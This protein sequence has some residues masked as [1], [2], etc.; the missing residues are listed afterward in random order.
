[1]TNGSPPASNRLPKW[2]EWAIY[3][4]FGVLLVSGGAWL[5]LHRLVTVAGA[6]GPEPSPFEP[7][8]LQIHGVVAYVFLVVAGA[9]IPNHIRLGWLAR[10]NHYT[11]TTTTAAMLVLALSG[12]ALYYVGSESLRPWTSLAHWAVGLGGAV[13]L[14]IHAGLV[15]RRQPL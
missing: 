11:G 8:L 13:A 6:F 5:I 2:Q 15:I 14:A 4:S 1:M 7:W 9:L 12:V 3:A 10:R